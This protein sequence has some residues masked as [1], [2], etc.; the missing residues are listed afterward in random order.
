MM[1]RSPF[2]SAALLL[3][4]LA[5]PA[6]CE[7][8]GSEAPSGNTDGAALA[9]QLS[10]PIASLISV[11]LQY[12][13]NDGYG[14]GGSQSTLNIQPVIPISIS[15]TWNVIS[16]TIIPLVD[17]H[18]LAP[19]SGSQTGLSNI[20]QSLFFSPKDPTAGGLIWGVGP[21]FQLPTA[22]DNVAPDQWAAGITGVALKQSG[23]WTVGAL[24]NHLWSISDEDRFGK[25]SATFVQPFLSYTTPKATSFTLNT[26]STHNWETDEWSVPI[27]FVV[28][29]VVKL[30]AQ[31]VQ[32]GLGARYWADAPED[33][34]DGWGLRA[35][36]TFLFPK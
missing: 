16:R 22:T 9:K 18:D 19:G 1:D 3:A 4:M 7:A 6:V 29:Q 14:G 8:Q 27:N 31:P 10:N 36:M 25:V 5:L 26:E 17:Q 20:T 23:P 2:R 12:N 32:L 34:P 28:S 33:G 21:V 30:G 24:A 13:Y 15:P 11:P 35:Q